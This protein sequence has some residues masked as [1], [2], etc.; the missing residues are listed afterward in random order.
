MTK[1]DIGTRYVGTAVRTLADPNDPADIEKA[2][3]LQDA[4]R[5]GQSKPGAFEASHWDL[6]GQKRVRDALLVL[7]ATLPDTSRAFGPKGEVD[8]VRRLL[9]AASAWGGNPERDALYLNLVLARNDGKT[10]YRLRVKGVPVDGFWSISLYNAEGYYE[11]NKYNAYT[12]NNLTAKKDKDGSITVQ[13]GGC[14]AEA[15]NCLPIMNG[16]NYMVRL[17]R[18]RKEI[19]EARGSFLKHNRQRDWRA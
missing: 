7:A 4:I 17:Y 13:F 14:D 19:L 12:L 11:A 16:W 6:E 2:V 9:C 1:Q 10:I 5:V 15:P 3:A 8:P 18:P